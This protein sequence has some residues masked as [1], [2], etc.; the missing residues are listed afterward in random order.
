MSE[1][2]MLIFNWS[3]KGKRGWR[4]R[5]E[6]KKR[7]EEEDG[8]LILPGL[9]L[10][11]TDELDSFPYRFPVSA[12]ISWMLTFSWL[13][14]ERKIFNATFNLCSPE[15]ELLDFCLCSF[16]FSFLPLGMI[17]SFMLLL[18]LLL[19][20]D[21]WKYKRDLSGAHVE[22]QQENSLCLT[23]RVRDWT[24]LIFSPPRSTA[25]GGRSSG[26]H[27]ACGAQHS[28]CWGSTAAPLPLE[29]PTEDQDHQDHHQD[30]H[31][32]HCPHHHY[33]FSVLPLHDSHS[34][35]NYCLMTWWLTCM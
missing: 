25:W 22:K 12:T 11:S 16:S 26:C 21:S 19:R 4:R 6:R 34:Q 23:S 8:T 35:K 14:E 24:R 20:T 28:D 5:I 2:K 29:S 1:S 27:P 31:P 30:H 10:T 33:N 32:H 18:L 7:E 3:R 13:K 9:C 15:R 17:F